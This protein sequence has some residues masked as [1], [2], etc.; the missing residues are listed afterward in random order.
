MRTVLG[1]LLSLLLFAGG[2]VFWRVRQS[3]YKDPQ[4]SAQETSE[5]PQ[6]A[7]ASGAA[8]VVE[9][10]A[11]R[12]TG[13]DIEWEFA[14][15][16]AGVFDRD[17]LTPIPDLGERQKEELGSLK[18][19]LTAN[20]VERKVLYIFA[21][22]DQEFDAKNPGRFGPCLQEWQEALKKDEQLL[23]S[24]GGK[25][26]LKARM[27]EKS[28]ID[29]YLNEV[30]FKSVKVTDAEIIEYYKNHPSEFRRPDRVTIRQVVLAD[31]ASANRVRNT[32]NVQNFASMAQQHSIA[33]EATKG[34]LLGPFA[35]SS[36]PG[37][38]DVAFHLK[39]GEISP[40]LKSPYGFHI[41][42]LVEKMPA[43][44]ASLDEVRAEI[45]H[46]LRQRAEHSEY[47]KLLER[48]LVTVRVTTPKVAW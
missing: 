45:S 40:V 33:P 14:L 9:V 22:Q 32:I 3:H 21:Q 17:S 27:C 41:M 19:A 42:T 20:I 31:E 36:M 10:G 38:F 6:P 18:K 44:L 48:A 25:H 4:P 29:Q 11:D 24:P 16:T 43:T 13:E 12:I 2:G 37:V 26:R 30:A 47:Q 39:R 23:H 7:V 5:A 46:K 1:V 8:T 15:A 34:G 28:L 35:R